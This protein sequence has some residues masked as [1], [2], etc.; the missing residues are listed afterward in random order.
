MLS[1]YKSNRVETLA[2]A[3]T[4]VLREPLPS[5]AMPEWVGVQTRGIRLWLE[6]QI[7]HGLGIW[8]NIH[9]PFP[10]EL[11]E[12]IFAAIPG[13]EEM[14]FCLFQREHLVW[15]VLSLLPEYRHLPEFSSLNR[16]LAGD[17]G[18]GKAFQ[19]ARKIAHVFDQY[20]VYRYGMLERWEKTPEYDRKLDPEDRWQPILWNALVGRFGPVHIAAAARRFFS[21]L[22]SNRIDPDRLPNRV[23]LFGIATLPPLYIDVFAG[24]S[25]LVP[26]HLF[27]LSP[28]KEFWAD[29]RSRRHILRAGD[30]HTPR[31]DQK[32]YDLHLEEGNVLLS[33]LGTLGRDFQRSIEARVDAYAE[34]GGDLYEDP[35]RT[36][37]P[38]LLDLLQ[39]DMLHLRLRRPG[40][41]PPMPVD[42]RDNSI[43]IHICHSPMREVQ[44]VHDQLLDM[45]ANDP[46]L[47]P[48]DVIVM[49]PDI[50]TYAPLIT[51]VFERGDHQE[52]NAVPY[53]I[54]DRRIQDE[55]EVI[56]GFLAVME[57]AE[58][59]I[60]VQEVFDLLAI[61][62]VRRRFGL[63][64]GDVNRAKNWVVESGVRWG[65]D[66]THRLDA[67]QP[68]ANENTWRF[69]LDR[70]LLGYALIHEEHAPVFD[71]VPFDKIEGKAAEILGRVVDFCDTL[72]ARLHHIRG[73]HKLPDW[74][75]RLRLILDLMAS[76][77]GVD[78]NQHQVVCD[79]L[80]RMAAQS[81]NAGFT[82]RVGLDVMRRMLTE[83]LEK[84]PSTRGFLSGGV[85]FCSFLPMR[86]IPFKVICLMGMND[87]AFPRRQPAASFDLTVKNPRP[88][89]RSMGD[90]DRYLFLEA[91]ISARRR[92]LI[93]YVGRNI[94]TNSVMPPSVVVSELLDA[95]RDGFSPAG[96][97]PDGMPGVD[98]VAPLITTHPLQPF[99]PRYFDGSDPA[100]FSYATSSWE[101]AV[102]LRGTRR[103]ET[104][105]LTQ[106]LLD[107]HAPAVS[108]DD[109]IVFF[110]NPAA[111]LLHK[112]LGLSFDNDMEDLNRREPVRLDGLAKF[113][114]GERLLK[115]A[116]AG[117]DIQNHYPVIR[118]CGL[119]PLGSPGR[120]IFKDLSA[121]AGPVGAAVR[122][123]VSD[124]PLP[125]VYVDR[126]VGGTRIIGTLGNLWPHHRLVYTFG[127]LTPH[128]RTALW[129]RHLI[130]NLITAET[131]PAVSVIVGRGDAGPEVHAFLP[132]PTRAETLLADLL[133]IFRR[134]RKA[135]LPFFQRSS[136]AFAEAWLKTDAQHRS[137]KA[138]AAARRV[139]RGG[140]KGYPGE[141]EDPYISRLFSQKDPFDRAFSDAAGSFQ[142]LA[143]A[144]YTPMIAAETHVNQE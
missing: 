120:L 104:P 105:F 1:L 37:A 136:Y 40:A 63:S 38:C 124:H 69:G 24:L 141:R 42:S 43:A 33:S 134:G 90:D 2:A 62:P 45:F 32:G 66:A 25:R 55:A 65:M 23:S 7:T 112:K 102:A 72:F 4:E 93:T 122:A 121:A 64:I 129:I 123:A 53:G 74:E 113:A 19:L 109:L 39:S 46:S 106:P 18:G 140:K 98:P 116:V 97:S 68:E 96:S 59:R 75:R 110:R 71:T 94:R 131:L 103:K 11:I 111:Y 127:R 44:V 107:D 80:Q 41:E 21:A 3:L 95:I 34:P 125:P 28:S 48:H 77:E 119:L 142:N 91:L 13:S 87:D 36:D 52:G 118:L 135:P 30:S 57:I 61:D 138:M 51:S 86:S 14:N 81:E 29:I 128:R 89:D 143:M 9:T 5:P 132:L 49:A 130:L 10:R 84:M 76:G 144:V 70:M 108:I 17:A 100:L 83:C 58:S 115:H 114:L 26:V 137:G 78:D 139:W 16:Y 54:S 60:T 79:L 85:T 133:M 99:S 82:G 101:G 35:A 117:R 92:L 31:F 22:V 8:A 20:A 73:T 50:Q 56:R 15:A 12:V 6:M 27:V 88:G 126:M 47:E 67:G